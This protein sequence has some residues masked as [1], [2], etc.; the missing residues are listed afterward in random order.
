[1][2][3]VLKHINQEISEIARHKHILYEALNTI[4]SKK[5]LHQNWIQNKKIKKLFI[6]HHSITYNDDH[7]S[8]KKT[9]TLK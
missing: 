9:T 8:A 6:A 4:N 7:F 3:L 5:N 1:L 2:V